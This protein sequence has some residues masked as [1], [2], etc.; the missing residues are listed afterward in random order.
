M[1]ENLIALHP[2]RVTPQDV[3][4]KLPPVDTILDIQV[5]VS[6]RSPD[7]KRL[8]HCTWSACRGHHLTYAAAYLDA[9]VKKMLFP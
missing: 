8:T 9:E 7:G 6:V 3:I 4:D 2:D 5:V 1:S